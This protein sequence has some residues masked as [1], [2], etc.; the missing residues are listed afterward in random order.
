[1]RMLHDFEIDTTIMVDPMDDT[2]GLGN[3]QENSLDD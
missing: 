1:M 3:Q 2:I